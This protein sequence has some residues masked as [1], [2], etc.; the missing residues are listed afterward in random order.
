MKI[1][2]FNDESMEEPNEKIETM[3]IKLSIFAKNG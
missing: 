2:T 3:R 1:E